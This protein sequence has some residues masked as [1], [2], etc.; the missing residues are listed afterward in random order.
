MA[1][2]ASEIARIKVEL[3]YNVMGNG[4]APWIDIHFIF[5]QI[6]QPFLT[7]GASTF[8]TT[9]VVGTGEPVSI[10]LEDITGFSARDRVIVD[11]DGRQ[12]S[13]T[14]QHINEQ[15]KEVL[16]ML[17]KPH[18]GTYPVTVEGGESIV[19]E[20]LAKIAAVKDQMAESM[21]TGTLKQVDE[22][23]FYQSGNSTQ[24]GALGE[25]LQYWRGELAAA[26]GIRDLWNRRCSAGSRMS[27]Y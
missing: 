18:S 17:A 5:E 23:Q 20:I 15:D 16:L 2:L 12:E 19:R 4:A 9:D 11:V 1:L 8:S 26:L 10:Y 6:I 21:G 13:A 22:I 27:V 7:S 3:G 24:F 25:Q 14:I